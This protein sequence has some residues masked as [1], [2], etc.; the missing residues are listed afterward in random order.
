MEQKQRDMT[1]TKLT[2]GEMMNEI[3]GLA[4]NSAFIHEKFFN[5]ADLFFSLLGLDEKKLKSLCKKLNIPTKK[6]N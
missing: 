4:K 3:I 6:A 2:K 5:G 1:T